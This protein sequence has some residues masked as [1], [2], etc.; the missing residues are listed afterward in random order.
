MYD[1]GKIIAGIIIFL[2]LITFPIWYLTAHSQTSHVPSLETPIGNEC[3]EPTNWML[4]NHMKLLDSWRNQAVRGGNYTYVASDG[5]EWDIALTG[6]CL[7][8]HDKAEFCD[9]CHSYEGVTPDCWSCHIS[10]PTSG[11]STASGNITGAQ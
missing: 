7:A 6:T 11:N 4:D 8:C 9:Q 2:I 3:I 5:K 10:S 1:K